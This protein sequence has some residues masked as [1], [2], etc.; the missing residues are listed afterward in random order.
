MCIRDSITTIHP[1]NVGLFTHINRIL[2]YSLS[3]IDYLG[4]LTVP[5]MLMGSVIEVNPNPGIDIH[6]TVVKHKK[7]FLTSLVA[8]LF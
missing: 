5:Y 2:N 4:D 3:G 6:Y 8:N 1:I 7:A